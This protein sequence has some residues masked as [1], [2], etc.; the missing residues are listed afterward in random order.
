MIAIVIFDILINDLVIG[1]FVRLELTND[2]TLEIHS[3]K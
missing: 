1:T 3:S 2:Q